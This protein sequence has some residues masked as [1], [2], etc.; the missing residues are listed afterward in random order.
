[1]TYN[2]VFPGID[3]IFLGSTIT[4]DGDCSHKITIAFSSLVGCNLDKIVHEKAFPSLA[5]GWVCDTS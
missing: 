3:F 2:G 1:M 4:V 5:K